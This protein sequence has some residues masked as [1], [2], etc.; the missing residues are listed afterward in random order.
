MNLYQSTI[1][2]HYHNP[3]FKGCLENPTFTTELH[4][5]SCGDSV[6][7]QGTVK[8]GIVTDIAFNGK[9]C[10]ISQAAASM[11]A[12]QAHGKSCAAINSYTQE[13]MLTMLGIDLGPMR[14]KCALL[15]LEAL[16]T[17]IQ[18]CLTGPS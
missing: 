18:S 16:H 2:D 4:N 3:H 7:W 10:V 5:P 12:Q 9:G 15:P 1:L 6:Y 11:L 17:G 13:T 14:I 8:N